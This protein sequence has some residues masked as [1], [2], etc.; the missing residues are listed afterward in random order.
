MDGERIAQITAAPFA[1]WAK[2]LSAH[3]ATP[4]IV[5]G[6]GHNEHEGELYVFTPS[7]ATAENTAD[8]LAHATEEG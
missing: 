4:T 3:Q 5:V 2:V 6:M 7:A 1:A 8:L